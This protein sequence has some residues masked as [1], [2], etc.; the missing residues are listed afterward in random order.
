LLPEAVTAAAAGALGIEVG[1]MANSLVFDADG[2]PMLVLTSGAHG[3]DTGK[4][5]ALVGAQR[6]AACHRSSYGPRRASRL[7]ACRT[8]SSRPSL[9]SWSR[10]LAASLRTSYEPWRGAQL[11]RQLHRCS[12]QHLLHGHPHHACVAS[13]QWEATLAQQQSP[14]VDGSATSPFNSREA[15]ISGL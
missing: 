11:S 7:V 5:A 2:T 4:V 1:Q 9:P 3:V 14:H 13:G 6:C 8:P 10:S 12:A 15:V